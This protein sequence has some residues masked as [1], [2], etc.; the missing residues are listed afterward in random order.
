[1]NPFTLASL[2]N[3]QKAE[4][5]TK[6][7]CSRSEVVIPSLTTNNRTSVSSADCVI[8]FQND[9]PRACFLEPIL[10]PKISDIGLDPPEANA[11]IRNFQEAVYL[12]YFQDTSV[13]GIM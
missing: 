7:C 2:P 13:G 11:M 3:S 9:I 1:M 10:V 8:Q 4:V 12:K 5:S 6:S